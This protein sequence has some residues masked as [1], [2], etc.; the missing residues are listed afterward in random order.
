MDWKAN[1]EQAALAAFA[2]EPDELKR[3]ALDFRREIGSGLAGQPSSLRL[4]PSFTGLPQG[5]E[6]GEYLALDFG[7]TNA[8]AARI[9]LTPPGRLEIICRAAR[10]LRDHGYDYTGAQA[11]AEELFGFLADL[12]AQAAGYDRETPL[13][14]GHTFSFPSEQSTLEDARLIQWTK[15]FAVPGVEG[16][17]VNSRLVTALCQ[18]GFHN[19][20]PVALINDTVAVLLAAAYAHTDTWL[21]SIYGTGHNTCYLENYGGQQPSMV[22]N[23]E[24]GGFS[25]LQPNEFDRRLDSQ[26]EKPGAQLLEKMVSGRYLGELFSLALSDITGQHIPPAVGT[27]LSALIAGAG[28]EAALTRLLGTAPDE[29]A[30]TGATRLA[31]AIVRRSARLVTA[32]FVGTLR[33]RADGS[34]VP[35]QSIG[36]EGSLYH[37]VPLIQQEIKLTLTELLGSETV[38]DIASVENGS[39]FGAAIAAAI[40]SQNP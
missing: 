23:M 9:R 19:I 26:S 20:K 22:L 30:V 6:C 32:T 35:P 24:S 2:V 34:P 37:F 27:D 15:E 16:C 36:I 25:H 7:G 28:G 3:I 21:G 40:V 1:K 38:P 33:H 31:A 18:K 4:L 39:L 10:P 13:L 14:L 17:P 8:R 12:I 29:T 5:T 11:T